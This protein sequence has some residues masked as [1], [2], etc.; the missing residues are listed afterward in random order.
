VS[1]PSPPGPSARRPTVAPPGAASGPA[2]FAGIP[3]WAALRRWLAAPDG[4]AV[5]VLVGLPLVVFVV[6]AALGYP[7]LSGDNL[8]QNF[9]LRALSGAQLRSGHLPLWNPYIWSGSPLLGGMNAGALYPGTFLFVVLPAMA[10]WVANLLLAYWAGGLGAYALGRQLGLRPLAALLAALTYGFGGAMAGQMVHLPIVQGMS[11][12]PLLVLALLRLAWSALGTGP[13]WA[14]PTTL[15]STVLLAVV[16]GLI[17][18]S[19]EPRGMAE[20]E[21]VGL[22]VTL[23]LALRPYAGATVGVGRRA[24]FFVH[25][26]VAVAWAALLGAVQLLPGWS[27]ITASQRASESY[28]YFAAGSLH[29]SWS[30]LL[31][32]PDVFGGDGVLHQPTW[33]LSYNLPEVTGYVGLLPLVAFVALLVRSVGRRRDPSAAEWAMWLFL[34]VLGLLMAFGGFT[35]VGRLFWHLPFFGKLRLQSRNLGILDFALAMLLG[36]WLDR[37]LGAA[38]RA[39]RSWGRWVDASPALAAA[40]LCAVGLAAPAA[41]ER[42]FGADAVGASL[43]RYL[44]PWFTAQLVLAAGV[45][46]AVAL[47]GARSS[48]VAL[49]EARAPGAPSAGGGAPGAAT[50]RRALPLPVVGRLLGV[51]VVADLSLF[52]LSS[53][54]GLTPGRNVTAEPTRAAAT[55]VLGSSGRFA[56]Y[57]STASRIETLSAIG[58][59]DLN[60]FT[61][62]PSV[63]GYG[64]LTY[65]PYQTPTGTRTLD[66]LDPCALAKGV[67]D[68]LRLATLVT[69]PQFLAPEALPPAVARASQAPTVDGVPADLV[70]TACPGAPRP[71]RPS[72]RTFYFG[73]V[74]DV[75]DV[76][77]V[78]GGA[79]A[80]ATAGAQ[81]PALGTGHQ[82]RQGT[83]VTVDLV[84]PRGAVASVPEQVV[85]V[86]PGRWSVHLGRAHR[87]AGI[88]VH[89]LGLQVSDRTSVATASGDRF[90][91]VG[92]LQDALGV[93]SAWRFG[94]FW[95]AYARFTATSV[96][97]PVWVARSPRGARATRVASAPDGTEVD[98]VVVPAGGTL[99]R[100]EAFQPGWR[101][102]AV[103]ARGG[104]ARALDV[105]ADGLVQSVHLPPGTWTVTFTY[106]APRLTE[107]L[108]ASAAGLVGLVVAGVLIGRRRLARRP[109]RLGSPLH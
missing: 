81:V 65:L 9:P 96:R 5:A 13:G 41:L 108:A 22:V 78:T 84:S 58:Q 83:P 42:A 89:A 39:E 97:P 16:L 69:L 94:G 74:L 23:W 7:A 91:M 109:R 92:Q 20:A 11:L 34:A 99:V 51:L 101:A 6:P 10:A 57:D 72:A 17:L 93:T 60:A 25:A 19:G 36:F 45:V 98:R 18:L 71:G 30:V 79:T 35:P 85:K 64:S 38:A 40:C 28:A 33:F 44:T 102:K 31:L 104:P 8:I 53:S 67:F 21:V 26:A 100:S 106:R 73:Q 55:A 50:G 86:G 12:V 63:Q 88:V 37:V 49:A 2:P 27:F 77:V 4:A 103:P 43:G 32:M 68:P 24:R 80:G 1:G 47:A 70:A 87:A 75:A 90:V 56:I 29:P 14:R 76:S 46:T 105:T 82:V 54:T 61:T 66:S 95:D 15:G 52:W 3:S 107:G 48:K 62:V 59:P